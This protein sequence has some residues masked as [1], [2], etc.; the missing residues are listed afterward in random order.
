MPG[1]S[2]T[3]GGSGD[4]YHV[5]DLHAAQLDLCRRFGAAFTPTPPDATVGAALLTLL[6]ALPIHGVRHAPR[7]PASGWLLWAG[8]F[9]T[10]PEF[11]QIVPVET[12]LQ[13]VPLV[14]PYLGLPP[15]WRFLLTPGYEDAWFD[16]SLIEG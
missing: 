7:G 15:G 1:W 2:P 6:P 9:S 8:D 10:D 4:R 13:H 16:A 11:F 14:L 12:L 5:S 3:S